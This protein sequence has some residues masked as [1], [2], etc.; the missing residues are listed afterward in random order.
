KNGVTLKALMASNPGVEPR[1][2]KIGA[3]LQLPDSATSST[4]A[5]TGAPGAAEPGD[6]S[7]YTVK[8]GDMLGRIAKAHGTTVSKIKALN[9]LKT[10]SIR[11][12]Q[13]LKLPGAKGGSEASTAASAPSAATTAPPA[14][15]AAAP[16]T[17]GPTH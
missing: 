15:Y 12:G 7:V 5:A 13:K 10:T 4:V 16:Q 9:D 17:A 14:L 11:V 1:K 6:T 8:A 2:L 3:K